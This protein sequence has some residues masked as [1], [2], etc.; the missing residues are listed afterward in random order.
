MSGFLMVYLTMGF[1]GK[2]HRGIGVI[3]WHPDAIAIPQAGIWMGG[4]CAL[5]RPDG[6]LLPAADAFTR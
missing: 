1:K 3:W 5:W 6:S 2:G 4:C